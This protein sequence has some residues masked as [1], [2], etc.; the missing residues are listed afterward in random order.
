VFA[1]S[2]EGEVDTCTVGEGVNLNHGHEHFNKSVIEFVLNEK[3]LFLIQKRHKYKVNV[4][5]AC[6]LRCF[7]S[8]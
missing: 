3:F 6:E 5:T 1:S 8:C 4:L 7:G 2:G